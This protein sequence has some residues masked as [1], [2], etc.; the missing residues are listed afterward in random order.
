MPQNGLSLE[1]DFAFIGYAA[2]HTYPQR[3]I[4]KGFLARC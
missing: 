1:S 2:D 4:F 3:A